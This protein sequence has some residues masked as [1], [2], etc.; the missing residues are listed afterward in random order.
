[1]YTRVSLSTD[2]NLRQSE[3]ARGSFRKWQGVLSESEYQNLCEEEKEE[4]QENSSAWNQCHNTSQHPRESFPICASFEL[5][6]KR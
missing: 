4:E 2:S 3:R 5:I 1:M 6:P